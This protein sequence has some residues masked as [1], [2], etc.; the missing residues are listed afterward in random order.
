[1]NNTKQSKQK[2][3][4]QKCEMLQLTSVHHSGFT[5]FVPKLEFMLFCLFVCLFFGGVG[6][7][8]LL[9]LAVIA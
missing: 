6:K 3:N 2:T 9:L 8:L 5:R 7:L 4:K 1:M